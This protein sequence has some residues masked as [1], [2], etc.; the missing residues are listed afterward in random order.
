MCIERRWLAAAMWAL[1]GGWNGLGTAVWAQ[2]RNAESVLSSPIAGGKPLAAASSEGP[3]GAIGSG[4]GHHSPNSPFAPL[5][6]RQDVVPWSTLTAVKPK[7]DASSKRIVPVFSAPVL[8]LHQKVVRVQGYMMP[9][10]PG[11]AQTHFLLSA[12]PLTC[13]FCTPGGPESI[14]EVFGKAPVSYVQAGIVVEGRLRVLSDDPKG[15]FYRMD[16]AIGV[17]ATP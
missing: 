16:G 7:L 4:A 1:M 17:N 14:I 6:A 12:V 15:V 2:P 10:A 5:V 13:S 8:A 11:M 9:L 3:G